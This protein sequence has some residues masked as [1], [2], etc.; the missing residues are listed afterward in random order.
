VKNYQGKPT[1]F[2]K[3]KYNSNLLGGHNQD[4]IGAAVSV[5]NILQIP[6]AKIKEAIKT[7]KSLPHR[8]EFVGEFRGVEFYDDAISTTPESTIMALKAIKNVD[9]IFLG[10]QDR[11]YNFSQLEKAVKRYK[12][13][14]IVLFP[15][16]GDKMLKSKKGLN[17]LRTKSMKEAV[18][19]AYKNT[20]QGSVCLLSCASPSYSL[21]KNFEEK[22]DQFQKFVKRLGKR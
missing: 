8:L 20:K 5:A 11:E 19:F 14:N 10:G 12:I 16:S 13:K 3:K 15:D 21:W 6:E 18:A 17:I 4:N 9:T 22:G 2:S 1:V 7:F